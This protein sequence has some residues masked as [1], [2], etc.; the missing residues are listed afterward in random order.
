LVV[1][2][3]P[4]AHCRPLQFDKAGSAATLPQHDKKNSADVQR[5]GFIPRGDVP[6]RRRR[7][8]EPLLRRLRLRH[9]N[10]AWASGGPAGT[11]L[12]LF[13]GGDGAHCPCAARHAACTTSLKARRQ[14][15]TQNPDICC[16]FGPG[17]NSANGQSNKK[18]TAASNF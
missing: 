4:A 18:N 15:R 9:K 6:G 14:A 11:D 2:P 1:V 12:W 8:F 10:S 17:A 13:A 3:A 7:M 5:G 16:S